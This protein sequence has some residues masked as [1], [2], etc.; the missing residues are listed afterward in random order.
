LSHDQ[1]TSPAPAVDIRRQ[2]SAHVIT[3]DTGS[4]R[5]RQFGLANSHLPFQPFA[6]VKGSELTDSQR[7]SS[8]LAT[9]ELV[10]SGRLT[11]GGAGNAASHRK[12]WEQAAAGTGGML[13]M[14]DDVVTH[15]DLAGYLD[16]HH[17]MLAQ[18]AVTH[19]GVNT[20][21]VLEAVSPQ[22][23]AL[24]ALQNP[25]HPTM[26][27]IAQ[28]FSLTDHNRCD[29]WRLL[30]AFGTCCYY[31]SPHGAA[32]LLKEVFP[33]SLDTIQVPFI[34]DNVPINATDRGMNRVYPAIAAFVTIPFLAYTPNVDSSTRAT[35]PA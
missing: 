35:T 4:P 28:A 1:F 8:G 14:E 20:D 5:F 10:A 30:R 16:G 19:F 12:L 22:G 26:E 24:T 2:W 13:I 9:P 23:L 6:G 3:M 18:T 32:T 15:V 21:S 27:W 17:A 29:L 34:G 25:K 11:H 31:V 33:L 7:I